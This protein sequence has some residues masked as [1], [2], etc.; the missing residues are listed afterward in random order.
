MSTNSN[1]SATN[2]KKSDTKLNVANLSA[3]SNIL[4]LSSIMKAKTNSQRDQIWEKKRIAHQQNNKNSKVSKP[5]LVQPISKVPIQSGNNHSKNSKRFVQNNSPNNQVNTQVSSKDQYQSRLF[6][7]RP[8]SVERNRELDKKFGKYFDDSPSSKPMDDK[9]ALAMA[10]ANSPQNG[11]IFGDSELKRSNI[12]KQRQMLDMQLQN[13][14]QRKFTDNDAEDMWTLKS[15]STSSKSHFTSPGKQFGPRAHRNTKDFADDLAAQI[16]MKEERKAAEKRRLQQWEMEKDQEIDAYDPFGKPGAGAPIRGGNNRVGG[17]HNVDKSPERFM[18]EREREVEELAKAAE[19]GQSVLNQDEHI[20]SNNAKSSVNKRNYRRMNGG[21]AIQGI[22]ERGDQ[23]QKNMQDD[24][25]NEI[26]QQIAER[27]RRKAEEKRRLEQEEY[28]EEQRIRREEEELAKKH[29]A[30]LKYE[31]EFGLD[32]LGTGG[33]NKKKKKKVNVDFQNMQHNEEEE[34][35]S[36]G[37]V[38]V[39][40]AKSRPQMQQSSSTTSIPKPVSVTKDNVSILQEN[41]TESTGK[42]MNI[43]P[44][45]LMN[46]K[47]KTDTDDAKNKEMQELFERLERDNDVLRNELSTLKKTVETHEKERREEEIRKEERQKIL[48]E[49]QQR[50]EFLANKQSS[51]FS[52]LLN[53][54]PQ[55]TR[56]VILPAKQLNMQRMTFEQRSDNNLSFDNCYNNQNVSSFNSSQINK[57]IEPSSKIKNESINFPTKIINPSQHKDIIDDL[58][59]IGSSNKMLSVDQ[60]L[61]GEIEFIDMSNFKG[62]SR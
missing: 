24:F 7:E 29:K 9:D 31:R 59:S 25:K 49:Q 58:L 13:R 30:D 52:F 40:G 53:A 56:Q 19:A 1:Q 45:S 23:F 2:A 57:S 41:S 55:E 36:Y 50:L 22:S 47:L 35:E 60:S 34:E 18:T 42:P 16:R 11:V 43:I 3:I 37:N 28:E 6:Q 61:S 33:A 32:S 38:M 15:D 17:N 21:N 5:P 12:N 46:G 10:F 54:L 44:A 39:K 48:F 4:P 51:E 14:N 27:K 20:N 26:E 62:F 8:P